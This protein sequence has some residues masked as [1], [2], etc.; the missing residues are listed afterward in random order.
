MLLGKLTL[1]HW[2]FI[3]SL[4]LA[5][6][7][8]WGGLN[9]LVTRWNKQEEYG[10]GYFI[11][12][13]TL[14]FL[15]NRKEALDQSTGGP[16]WVGTLFVAVGSVGLLLGELTAIY[17]LI[18]FGF[19]LTLLGLV[20]AYGGNSLLKVSV[21]PILFLIFAIPLPYF[22]DAQISWRLQ[23]LSSQ[24]GVGFLRFLGTSVFLEGNVI[25]LGSYKLQVVEACSGLRYLYPL[26]SIGF[27]MAYMYKAP[28]WKKVFIFLSTIPITVIMNSAR[29]A[30]VG[31][32]VNKW[33]SDQAE[34]FVHYFEGWI[35]FMIC[36]LILVAEIMLFERFG[37]KRGFNSAVDL[38]NIKS[39]PPKISSFIAF[40][41]YTNIF[42]LL[43]SI[44]LVNVLGHREEVVPDR[45]SLVNFPT[46]IAGWKST[47]SSLGKDVLKTLQLDD[48]MIGDYS[49]DN[50]IVNL[51]IAYYASQRKGVSPHS[52][53]VCMPGGGWVISSL[54]RI[55]I[56]IPG[57][58]NFY[59]NRTIINK[60]NVKQVVYYWFEQRG[61]HIANEYLMKW[62][63]LLDSIKR[64]RSDG[65]L[66]RVTTL[67]RPN[68]SV[69]QADQR[70]I[71]FLEVSAPK[72]N[73]YIPE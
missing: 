4:L 10:H 36:L 41:S 22:I 43:L 67:I 58:T 19:I 60:G 32:L 12:L 44:V 14:W 20:L 15:W 71:Q 68:E 31:I 47:P 16:S 54:D 24:L 5:F 50:S 73:Q 29:I 7:A 61:R 33:G 72:M 57:K 11:P 45:L 18:Q 13:I 49:K 42:I 63:L 69:E 38:P 46:E 52:P 2:L 28:L 25:D 66:V 30:M 62:Y 64:N 3:V 48:Y 21:L 55:L 27:L 59:V 23:I 65:A 53:Q 56:D 39:V 26:L 1:K 6:L 9:E 8:Y 34:G 70:I 51:Y 17:V 37:L 35:I 40:P